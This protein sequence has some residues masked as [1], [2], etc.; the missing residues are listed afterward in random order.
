MRG[1]VRGQRE[2]RFPHLPRIQ[3][4]NLTTIMH[5]YHARVHSKPCRPDEGYQCYR[6]LPCAMWTDPG[7]LVGEFM[8]ISHDSPG[9]FLVW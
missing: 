3:G 8:V 1:A 9:F 5:R 7:A 6:R 2:A 4:E